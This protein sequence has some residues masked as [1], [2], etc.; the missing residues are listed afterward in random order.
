[1]NGLATPSAQQRQPVSQIRA[2][3]VRLVVSFIE[4]MQHPLL[5][6]LSKFSHAPF[7]AG[8]RK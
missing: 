3:T 5:K 6:Q 2:S 7:G 1:M 4:R 8:R